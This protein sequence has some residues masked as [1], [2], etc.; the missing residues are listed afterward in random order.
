MFKI[1]K[2][3][4]QSLTLDNIFFLSSYA[5]TKKKGNNV[6]QQHK[7]EKKKKLYM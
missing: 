2:A 4:R 3:L 1:N 6:S 7:Q 5:L